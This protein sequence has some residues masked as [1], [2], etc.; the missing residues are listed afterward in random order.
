[1]EVA[2]AMMLPE[3]TFPVAAMAA[4]ATLP[5]TTPVAT[6]PS[7]A[8]SHSPLPVY[9]TIPANTFTIQEQQQF[10]MFNVFLTLIND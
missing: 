8:S 7:R 3:G 2:L 4:A 1:M 5:A 6:K 9:T 10:P